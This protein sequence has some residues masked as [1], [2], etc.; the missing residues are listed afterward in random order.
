MRMKCE[1]RFPCTSSLRVHKSRK[2]VASSDDDRR[3]KVDWLL[4]IR[5]P[6]IRRTGSEAGLDTES[7]FYFIFIFNFWERTVRCGRGVVFR[8]K[9]G[10]TEGLR[11]VVVVVVV[12]GRI[13]SER[14]VI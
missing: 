14:G 9:G 3:S 2:L 8:V 11:R 6:Y 1:M 10:G 7:L 13:R 5:K 4:W 12:K